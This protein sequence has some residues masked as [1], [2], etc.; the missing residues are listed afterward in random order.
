MQRTLRQSRQ[1]GALNLSARDL[2]DIPKAVFFPNMHMESDEQHWE[3]RDLVKLDLSY[4]DLVAV[5]AD[6]EQ[7]QALTWLKLKQ[8]QL[9]DIPP[10]LAS[11]TSLVYLDL[12]NN[13]LHEASSFLGSLVRLRELSLSANVLTSLPD[14]LGL[15]VHLETLALHDNQLV[16]IPS[17]IAHLTKL[18]SVSVQQNLLETLPPLSS[19]VLL[20]T[21]DVSKNKLA[22]MPA[23]DAL[24]RLKS[25]DLRHN[26]LDDL[27]TLPSTLTML[28]AGHNRLRDLPQLE[29]LAPALTVL[30][31]RCNQLDALPPSIASLDFLTSLDVSNNNL[32]DLPPGLGSLDAL[33]HLVLDGNPLRAIRQSVVA[34]GCV[35]LK[36]YLQKRTAQLQTPAAADVVTSTAHS[37]PDHFIRDACASGV[38]DLSNRRT[39]DLSHLASA[40][41]LGASLIHLNMSHNGLSA[42]PP[43]LASLHLL[44]SLA[45]ENNYLTSLPVDIAELPRLQALRVQKNRLTDAALAA[46]VHITAPIRYTLVELD[47]RNNNLTKVP[48]GLSA[49]QLLDTLLVSFNQITALDG[50]HW[51]NMTKLTS[52]LASNNR[53]ESL[54]TIYVAPSLT[55]LNV[56]NNALR[57]IPIELGQTVHLRLVNIQ[58]N[59][60]RH[61]RSSVVQR[62]PHAVLQHLQ[63]LAEKPVDLTRAPAK[64]P[65]DQSPSATWQ[66][67]DESPPSTKRRATEDSNVLIPVETKSL[68]QQIQAAEAEMDGFGVSSA[69][70]AALKKELA[71][72]RKQQAQHE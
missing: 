18:R 24:R 71:N 72:L 70:L 7:L 50:V 40:P 55:S 41:R 46:V 64:R 62:G 38:L 10:Q 43:G 13:K 54:G 1:S 60:Q 11:L 53:L 28:F 49:F 4:N 68:A 67:D 47:V 17:S 30:D 21:L 66:N 23:L 5:P 8:N 2:K 63:Q 42:L 31:V 51:A 29:R 45:A 3:C 37:I 15:L 58:G 26:R 14:T 69:R 22:A 25:V 57:H 27:P 34:G 9:T 59:P 56:E 52:C 20:E 65:L 33:N 19:L 44:Q 6:V 48:P 16:C 12:S 35:A 39:L 32:S 36:Q 61:I